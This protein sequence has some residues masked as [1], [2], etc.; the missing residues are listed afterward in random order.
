[1]SMLLTASFG[2]PSNHAALS[3]VLTTQEEEAVKKARISMERPSLKP[4]IRRQL[5]RKERLSI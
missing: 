4:R 5:T 3:T 1:M 2:R